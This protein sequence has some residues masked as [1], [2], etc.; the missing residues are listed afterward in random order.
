MDLFGYPQV[1]ADQSGKVG[2]QDQE[3]QPVL[4]AQL[5]QLDLLDHRVLLATLAQ[6]VHKVFRELLQ[7]KAELEQLDLPVHQVQLVLKVLL[8]QTGKVELEQPVQQVMLE[9]PGQDLQVLLVTLDLLDQQVLL[10][11]KVLLVPGL[12][13]QLVLLDLPV[14]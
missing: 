5:V 1:Q 14:L 10:V 3:V 9:Q 12:L 8:G 11:H 4:K 7:G 13:A 6:L 2:L